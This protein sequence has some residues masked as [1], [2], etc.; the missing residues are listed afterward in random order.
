MVI[1]IAVPDLD[2]AAVPSLTDRLGEVIEPASI[3]LDGG[4]RE[5]RVEAELQSEGAVMHVIAAVQSWLAEAG[6][7]PSVALSIG[8]RS[9]TMVGQG[10]IARGL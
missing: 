9:Y 6:A 4:H 5:V 8:D 10:Q 2:L 1:R 7:S 3:R